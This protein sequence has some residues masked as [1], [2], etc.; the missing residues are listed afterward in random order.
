MQYFLKPIASLIFHKPFKS[1][2]NSQVYFWH[3][4]SLLYLSEG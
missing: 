2:E 4:A 3:Y 1:G